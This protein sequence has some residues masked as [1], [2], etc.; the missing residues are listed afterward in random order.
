MVAVRVEVALLPLQ[1]SLDD[2]PHLAH[3]D[4]VGIVHEVAQQFV[5]VVQI[6]VVVVHLVVLLRIATDVAV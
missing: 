5:H 2:G 1:M 4:R 3:V 6:H